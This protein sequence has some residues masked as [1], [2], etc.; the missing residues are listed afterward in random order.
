MTTAVLSLAFSTLV[1]VTGS[2]KPVDSNHFLLHGKVVE[3]D[4][5]ASRE[6]P[7]K[8]IQVVVYQDSEI[9]VAFN[10]DSKGKYEFN[11]PVDH[12]YVVVFGTGDF[13]QK[14][15]SIDSH[16]LSRK[17]YGHTVKLDMG[18]FKPVSGVDFAFLEEPVAKFQFQSEFDRI[19]PDEDY[20]F[21]KAKE[22][23]KC[24]KKILKNSGT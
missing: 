17:K 22:M 21:K 11:L 5:S 13:V 14:K 9:Y 20:G 18:L 1:A 10:T 16:E 2:T 7:G 12:D 19:A 15:V 4:P 8:E 3:V 6:L 23:R 24:Y